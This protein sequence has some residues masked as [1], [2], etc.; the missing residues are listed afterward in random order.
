MIGDRFIEAVEFDILESAIRYFFRSTRKS[1]APAASSRRELDLRVQLLVALIKQRLQKKVPEF[2]FVMM[3]AAARFEA[4]AEYTRIMEARNRGR[5][6]ST[7]HRVDSILLNDLENKLLAAKYVQ[8]LGVDDLLAVTEEYANQ[9]GSQT[10]KTFVARTG[11]PA[12]LSI[13]NVNTAGTNE[14]VPDQSRLGTFFTTPSFDAEQWH[15]YSATWSR[16]FRRV[17]EALPDPVSSEMDLY[18]CSIAKS[19]LYTNFLRAAY[20]CLNSFGS[21]GPLWQRVAQV[22]QQPAPS[23]YDLEVLVFLEHLCTQ[24]QK[25]NWR[26]RRKAL[27]ALKNHLCELRRI[28]HLGCMDR[29]FEES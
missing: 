16:P 1:L 9:R 24:L 2:D 14:E 5:R 22:I 7:K 26:G 28:T 11:K 6:P 15:T 20:Q 8:R 25:T 19:V 4:R 29:Y 27:A 17:P 10:E 21:N 3:A 12:V 18:A 13:P 23:V